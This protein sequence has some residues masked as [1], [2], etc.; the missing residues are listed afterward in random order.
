MDR[1]IWRDRAAG[2]TRPLLSPLERRRALLEESLARL[3]VIP[4]CSPQLPA[5]RR[6]PLRC[7]TSSRASA[8][9]TT[10][11]PRCDSGAS[12][13]RASAQSAVQRTGLRHHVE[14]P[15]RLA[16]PHREV[17][18]RI[19]HQLG[20]R[21]SNRAKQQAAVERVVDDGQTR[22]V[23][24]SA[25]S[26]RQPAGR[27]PA[28]ARNRHRRRL[29][30]RRSS[31]AAGRQSPGSPPVPPHCRS[32]S[33]TVFTHWRNSRCR[34]RPRNGP[35]PRQDHHADVAT[36]REAAVDLRQRPRHIAS[37]TTLRFSG[38]VQRR[39][40]A[41]RV[42]IHQNVISHHAQAPVHP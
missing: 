39:P 40:S 13:I 3:A 12:T 7:S 30:A 8:S 11:A 28:P 26:C 31:A 22:Q 41:G 18:A 35:A 5:R 34:H 21:Q 32:V 14:Q 23:C 2:T 42:H 36:L 29:L 24:P 9:S 38:S 27:T 6:S 4:R 33:S 15:H 37:D 17:S 25:S 16:I 1:G 20:I 10:L 19:K